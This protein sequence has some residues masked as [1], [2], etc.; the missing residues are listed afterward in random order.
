M[1][2]SLKVLLSAQQ[3][4]LV[5]ILLCMP[6]GMLAAMGRLCH[7]HKLHRPFVHNSA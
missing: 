6:N 5:P 3:W 4:P 2:E 7:S 1:F